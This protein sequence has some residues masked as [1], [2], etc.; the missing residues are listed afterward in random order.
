MKAMAVCYILKLFWGS[1][2]LQIGWKIHC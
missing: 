2:C 1:C